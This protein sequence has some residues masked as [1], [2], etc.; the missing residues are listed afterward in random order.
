MMGEDKRAI[1]W[2]HRLQANR[3]F[4]K[5]HFAKVDE[6]GPRLKKSVKLVQACS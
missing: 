5:R 3:V 1:A 6:I 4:C 2:K